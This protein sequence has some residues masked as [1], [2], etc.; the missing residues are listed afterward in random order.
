MRPVVLTRLPNE[1]RF[2]GTF[3][4]QNFK[5]WWVSEPLPGDVADVVDYDWA[6]GTYYVAIVRLTTNAYA[7]YQSRDYGRTWRLVYNAPSVL[8][9]VLRVDPGWMLC[10]ASDGWYESTNSGTNWYKISSDAPGCRAIVNVGNDTLLAHD[11]RKVWKS[12]NRG[13]NWYTV[14]NPSW[15]NDSY[16]AIDGFGRQVLAAVGGRLFV[17][18]DEGNTWNERTAHYENYNIWNRNDVRILQ[19]IL[20]RL[21][22]IDYN[23]YPRYM[24]RVYFKNLGIVRHYYISDPFKLGV[25]KFDQ[26]F[27][28]YENGQLATH[29]I[30]RV[31][32]PNIESMVFSS[33]MRFNTQR[34]AYEPSLKYSLDGGITWQDMNISEFSVYGIDITGEIS[35]GSTPTTLD[36]WVEVYDAKDLSSYPARNPYYITFNVK[37]T[38]HATWCGNDIWYT[39]D[40][41]AEWYKKEVMMTFDADV[42]LKNWEKRTKSFVTDLLI[43]KDR[44]NVIQYLDAWLRKAL[45]KSFTSR[46]SIGVTRAKSMAMREYLQKAFDSEY[47]SDMMS[48][49]TIDFKYGEMDAWLQKTLEFNINNKFYSRK[50]FVGTYPIRAYMQRTHKFGFTDK[51][52]LSKAFNSTYKERFY[53]R[54]TFIQE[55]PHDS[56]LVKALGFE[57]PVDYLCRTELGKVLYSDFYSLKPVN[58]EFGANVIIVENMFDKAVVEFERVIPQIFELWS[59]MLR[60]DVFDSRKD[61]E[62]GG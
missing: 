22:Y 17:S 24:M 30:Q 6:Y 33:Q 48:V 54:K 41:H 5:E 61:I 58:S 20:T 13:R 29:I 62:Y 60:Y 40:V 57:Y 39:Y 46:A 55:L 26:P 44:I 31:G 36:A 34:N 9:N 28:G 12:T 47:A 27:S 49:G 45:Q 7:I 37:Y 32:T 16:P 50:T 18:N 35:G 4:V 56:L 11:G 3:D 19:I 59:K 52:L 14:L 21:D 15:D 53:S 25:A 51:L 38:R 2:V 1:P 43:R 23:F 10:S 8:Y 42:Y